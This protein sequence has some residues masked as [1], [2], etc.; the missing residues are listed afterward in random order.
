[1]TETNVDERQFLFLK[2]HDHE[3]ASNSYLMSLLALMVGF[4]L[5]IVNLIATAIFFLGNRKR[6][7]LCVG[8]AHKPYLCK[9]HYS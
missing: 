7:F 6:S 9:C 5:P 2:E 3:Q 4:P 8:I 1:M